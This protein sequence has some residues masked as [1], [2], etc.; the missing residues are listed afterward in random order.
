[1]SLLFK[2]IVSSKFLQGQLASAKLITMFLV[3]ILLVTMLVSCASPEEKAESYYAKGMALL[4]DD[5]DK[6][7]LEFQNALQIKKN[8]TKAMYGIALVAERKGDWKATF[9]LLNK[10][11]EQEP[12]HMDALVKT[13]Q[14]LL[15]GGV[16]DMA[17][18]R[19]NKA[20]EVDKNNASAL[21]LHAAIQLK[22]GNPKAA[23]DYAN[24]AL[25]IAPGDQDAYVV[26]ASERLAAKD[27]VKAIE[28]LDQALAKDKKNIAVQLIRIKA[29]ENLSKTE[30]AERSY[31]N[32]IKIFPDTNAIRK[33]YAQFLV[34]N[35]RMIEAEQQL[36]AI[37]QASPKELQAKLDVIRFLIAT[38]GPAAGR[39]ELE[40]YVKN[41][42]ENYELVFSLVNLYQV[43]KESDKEDALLRQVALKAGDTDNGFKARALMAYKHMQSGNKAEAEKVINTILTKDSR[44]EQALTLRANIALEAKNYEAAIAD[45]RT[46]LRDAP[47]STGAILMLA[48]AHERTGANELADEQYAKAFAISKFSPD[49]GLPYTQFLMRNKHPARAEKVLEQMM[50]ANPNDAFVMRSLAQAKISRGDFSGAQALADRAKRANSKSNLSD[51]ILG[52]ISS[53]QHDVEATLSAFKR[54]HEVDPNDTQPIVAIVRTYMQD[55]KSKEAFA[56]IA[57][58]LKTN[59]NNIDA[60]LILGQLYASSGNYEDASQAYLEVISAK[61]ST[62]IAYQQLAAVQF[63]TKQAAEA[64]KTI[65][66][67]L[68]AAPKDFGLQLTQASI[69]ESTGRYD[70]AINVYEAMLKDRPDSEI[71]ANNLASMLSDH[72]TDKV[73]INRAYE[74]AKLLKNSLAPQFLDTFGWASFKAGKLG[75]AEMALKATIDKAPETAIYHYHLAKIY[76]AKNDNIQAKLALKDAV[77]YASNEPFDQKDEAIALLKSL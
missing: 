58:V 70:E 52:A 50:E 36:R 10:V 21:N 57:D 77:K 61:P 49:F 45:L 48:N 68:A 16:L 40:N 27:E 73:S 60:K 35:S 34:Q 2:N 25:A 9:S 44:N 67:G 24:A 31:L 4:K 41:A 18:E 42:P 6:A 63:K 62:A 47:N 54:A 75:E 30:E 1:M 74:L 8:M 37:A 51:Q 28:F 53:G 43:Q 38:K 19:S 3:N 23:I 26:L 17:L 76:I 72:R 56:F 65:Q 32:V 7:K 15:A 55:G 69:Y 13:G 59:P 71:V 64:E 39:T 22:L 12:S 33:N 29:L 14:I 66:Q 5:P 20:L 11:L 46:I